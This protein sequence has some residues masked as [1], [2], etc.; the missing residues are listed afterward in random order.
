MYIYIY[1]YIMSLGRSRH[2]ALQ[3]EDVGAALLL[4]QV[5]LVAALADHVGHVARLDLHALDDAPGDLGVPA[6]EGLGARGVFRDS[7]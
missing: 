4:Q 3:Q 1:I 6:H 2:L 5:E 7:L